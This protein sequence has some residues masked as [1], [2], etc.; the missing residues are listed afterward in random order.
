MA[1]NYICV[2]HE[3][4]KSAGACTRRAEHNFKKEAR[5]KLDN[6]EHSKTKNN[7][8]ICFNG[9]DDKIT[10][11]KNFRIKAK[12]Y[13]EAKG[14]KLRA[15][16]VPVIETVYTVSPDVIKTVEDER[17]FLRSVIKTHKELVGSC[18]FMLDLHL[19]ETTIH[20]HC[21]T[22]PYD[23]DL[24]S[25]NQKINNKHAYSKIQD[26]FA[27][28]CR[29]QKIEVIRGI[30]KA[31]TGA[32]HEK[33]RQWNKER[34]EIEADYNKKKEDFKAEQQAIYEQT[35]TDIVE[36]RKKYEKEY[37]AKNQKIYDD[38]KKADD[39]RLEEK[40]QAAGLSKNFGIME[41]WKGRE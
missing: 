19:D 8:H 10:A 38:Y 30:D 37:H 24:I 6:V 9:Y 4:I 1:N 29:T 39:K 15:D 23:K 36:V 28:N 25:Y 27:K 3:T 12:A 14:K 41:N 16:A 5:E 22:I 26:D 35:C 34:A 32:K 11:Y 17:A 40:L 21:I 2:R 18:P 7:I 13:K 31:L 20:A 33:P